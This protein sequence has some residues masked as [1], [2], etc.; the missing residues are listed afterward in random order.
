M[1]QRI[2]QMP[3]QALPAT[4]EAFIGSSVNR[5]VAAMTQPNSGMKNQQDGGTYT[6]FEN[7]QLE[8]NQM[9][10]MQ[11]I[12]QNG[13]SAAPQQAAAGIGQVTNQ[14]TQQST[15]EYQAQIGMNNTIANIMEATGNGS[16]TMEMGNPVLVDKR[17][18]DIAVS[19]AMGSMQAAELGQLQA[20]ARRYG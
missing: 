11:N 12:Q 19:R 8:R 15:A 4:Q 2:T 14:L 17:M 1:A 18:N 10:L 9:Q 20:E 7:P 16:A 13:I 5:G 3:Q 6:N